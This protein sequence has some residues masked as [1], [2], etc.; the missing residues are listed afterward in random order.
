MCVVQQVGELNYNYS[1]EVCH[2]SV[3]IATDQRKGFVF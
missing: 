3:N 1:I 2:N